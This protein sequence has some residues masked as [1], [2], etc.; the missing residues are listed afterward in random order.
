MSQAKDKNKEPEKLNKKAE[1]EENYG[2]IKEERVPLNKWTKRKKI[3]R[4]FLLVIAVAVLFGVIARCSYGIS[5]YVIQHFFTNNDREQVN[6]PPTPTVAIEPGGKEAP[7]I[8]NRAFENFENVMKGVQIASVAL[9][10]S[11]VT[12]SYV[13]EIVDPVFSDITES[14]TNVSGVVI[15][16]NGSEFLIYTSYSKMDEASFDKIKVTFYG[17]ISETGFVYSYE[18]EA[19]ALILSVPY[20][21][22]RKNEVESIVEVKFGNSTDLTLGSAVIALGFPDGQG[23][24]VDMGFITS[25]AQKVYISDMSLEILRTNILGGRGESGI[26]VNTKGELVGLITSQFRDGGYSVEAISLEKIMPLMRFLTNQSEYPKFGAK[27]LDIEDDVLSQLNLQNGI[28]IE[29]V[30]EGSAAASQQFRQGDIITKVGDVPVTSVE[31]FFTFYTSYEKNSTVEITYYRNGKE[32]K[33]SF[34]ITF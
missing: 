3:L 4:S 9:Q 29:E 13:K 17:G 28:I 2:F 21:N 15:A 33:K 5:D 27:F 7:V 16:K 14:M 10:P 23:P 22:F 11:L 31:E 8:D 6:L 34:K 19:D 24:S 12:V 20:K 25:R 26:L 18:K 1:T 30:N 32:M